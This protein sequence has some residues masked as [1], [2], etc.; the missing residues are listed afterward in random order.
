MTV[1]FLNDL[2]PWE[3]L[4]IDLASP[5]SQFVY[6]YSHFALSSLPSVRLSLVTLWLLEHAGFHLSVVFC[7]GD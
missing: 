3:R 7:H 6:H 4:F 1:R 5:H 2:F